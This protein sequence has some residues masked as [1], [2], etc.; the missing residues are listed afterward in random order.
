[1]EATSQFVRRHDYLARRALPCPTA[2]ARLGFKRRAPNCRTEFMACCMSCYCF[3]SAFSFVMI[4]SKANFLRS[5]ARLKNI[6]RLKPLLLFCHATA[7]CNPFEFKNNKQTAVILK[8]DNA[9]F[10][11]GTTVARSLDYAHIQK[12]MCLKHAVCWWMPGPISMH[13][14]LTKIAPLFHGLTGGR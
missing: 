5:S 8:R 13:L 6:R 2:V 4:I 10:E 7:G 3:F 12:R 14:I 1:M 11:F 9:C